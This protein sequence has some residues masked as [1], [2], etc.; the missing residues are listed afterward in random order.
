MLA[1]VLQR[2]SGHAPSLG[3]LAGAYDAAFWWSLGIA[4]LS[5]IP[6]L[7]LL[8][9]EDPRARRERAAAKAEAAVEALGA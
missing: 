8:R 3:K 4:M 6:C 9:A 1:V 2:A 7:V 5:L